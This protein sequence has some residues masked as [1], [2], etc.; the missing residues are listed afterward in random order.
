MNDN[1]ALQTVMTAAEAAERWG[2]A[3]RRIQGGGAKV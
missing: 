1:K 2:K 3:D